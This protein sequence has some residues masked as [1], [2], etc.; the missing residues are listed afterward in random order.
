MRLGYLALRPLLTLLPLRWD[1]GSLM[2]DGSLLVSDGD[3]GAVYRITDG[4]GRATH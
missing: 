4:E 2:Q 3:D 1:C